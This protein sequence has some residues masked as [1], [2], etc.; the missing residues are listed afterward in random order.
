MDEFARIAAL[1]RPL[2]RGAP[3]ALDLLDDAAMLPSTG[4]EALV[5][6]ND[7]LVEGVHFLPNTPPEDIAAKALGANLSD[8]AAMGAYPVGYLLALALTPAHD[9][10]WLARF[11]QGLAAGQAAFDLP[12]LGGDSVS[13]PGPLT[14]SITAFGRCPP[15]QMLRRSGASVGDV[16]WVSGTLG[17]GALGLLADRG[18]L[19]PDLSDWAPYLRDRYRRPRPRVA[20]GQALRGVASA[21]M[22][23]SDGIGGD[24]DKLC[25]ASGVGMVIDCTAIP[26]SDAARAV[27][28][29]RPDLQTL[30]W[31]G[32]DDYELLFTAPVSAGAALEQI[33][34]TL[35]LPLTPIGR[36]QAGDRTVFHG[37]DGVL[38]ALT[39]WTHT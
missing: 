28:A 1:F 30:A 2:T 13:T 38:L 3:G 26:L 9:E 15:G 39:G 6:T 37:I 5:T 4:G 18:T 7:A 25:R 20:L 8:L 35:N 32:G 24:A 12:L 22:D 27:L 16:V 10:A 11:T 19:N 14:L 17:D 31:S 36:V 23:V 21:A 29:V 34:S 33:A